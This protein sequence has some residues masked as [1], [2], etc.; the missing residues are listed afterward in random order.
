MDLYEHA[1]LF[2][3]PFPNRTSQIASRSIIP[4]QPNFCDYG[5]F[6][7]TTAEYKIRG[8][9]EEQFDYSQ[10]AMQLIRTKIAINLLRKSIQNEDA[11]ALE[12]LDLLSESDAESNSDSDSESEFD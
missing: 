4:Q 8:F 10:K 11:S 6:S 12:V 1:R 9:S 7:L 3:A 5:I 2:G